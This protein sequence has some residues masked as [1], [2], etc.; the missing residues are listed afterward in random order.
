MSDEGG[1][2]FSLCKRNAMLQLKG[3]KGPKPWSTGTTI[4][5]AVF[6]V[7]AH[8]ERALAPLTAPWIK[9]G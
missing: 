5:G 8:A 3:M 1:F 9:H 7:R 2:D 6:A 4:C